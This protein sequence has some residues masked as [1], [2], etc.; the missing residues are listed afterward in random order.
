[1]E[2]AIPN[3]LTMLGEAAVLACLRV[4]GPSSG[5][6][7]AV[8]NLYA[9]ALSR[10]ATIYVLSDDPKLVRSLSPGDLEGGKFR[11]GGREVVFSDGRTKISRLAVRLKELHP[12]IEALKRGSSPS[13]EQVIR[14]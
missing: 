6:S 14:N 10:L 4:K 13:R 5:F 7:L 11:D 9:Q 2:D 12:A 8:L 1:M 3:D